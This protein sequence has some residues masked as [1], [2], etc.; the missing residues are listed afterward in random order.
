M[1]AVNKR[2]ICSTP[3]CSGV[4]DSIDSRFFLGDTIC[5]CP[6][7]GKKLQE[8]KETTEVFCPNNSNHYQANMIGDDY[9]I[10][11]GTKLKIEITEK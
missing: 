9:C 10:I 4:S 7:C 8:I 1:K 3:E 2:L 11:C 6:K 5:Y